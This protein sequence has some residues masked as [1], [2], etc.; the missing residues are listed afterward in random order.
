M[1][2]PNLG[3]HLNASDLYEIWAR[4]FGRWILGAFQTV[5]IRII[6]PL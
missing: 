4:G 1:C 2:R 6:W 5:E 3:T